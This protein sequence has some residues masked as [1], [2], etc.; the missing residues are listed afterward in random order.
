[1]QIGRMLTFF[2]AYLF[3]IRP[4]RNFCTWCVLFSGAEV[5]WSNKHMLVCADETINFT[6]PAQA[7]CRLWLNDKSLK[8]K[9]AL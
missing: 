6:A 7:L 4:E 5:R 1:M 2:G 9:D 3:F 8:A